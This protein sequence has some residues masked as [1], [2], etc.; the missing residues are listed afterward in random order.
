MERDG[1]ILAR[2]LR[3]WPGRLRL[4]VGRDQRTP[5]R[6]RDLQQRLS[7][8]PGVDS[9]AVNQRTGSVLMR[10]DA[11]TKLEGVIGDVV[12]VVEESAPEAAPEAFAVALVKGLD[13]RLETV[14][15]GRVS[16]RWLV[17]ATFVGLGVRQLITQG[18]T[19]G[20]IPWY[21]LIYYGVDSFLKLYPEYAPRP[22]AAPAGPQPPP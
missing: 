22:P 8:L 9:V 17:P 6:M 15:G 21:V 16:L 20:A 12:Q 5:E 4:R 11:R 3:S 18:F 19:L 13:D 2:V 7:S 1:R 10:G 14:S